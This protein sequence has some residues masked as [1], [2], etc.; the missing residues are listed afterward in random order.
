MNY[1]ESYNDTGTYQPVETLFAPVNSTMIDLETVFSY[2]NYFIFIVIVGVSA[3][4]QVILFPFYIYVHRVNDKKD[5]EV[6]TGFKKHQYEKHEI[7]Q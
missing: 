6:S 1:L 5:R 4:V 3:F 2:T 7:K